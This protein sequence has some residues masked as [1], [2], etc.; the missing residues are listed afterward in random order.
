[1]AD[2]DEFERL[3]LALQAGDVMPPPAAAPAED[4]TSG[5]LEAWL[6]VLAERGGSDLLL[7]AG[8]PPAIR[9]EG[10]VHRLDSG[11]LDSVEIEEAVVSWLPL[12]ARRQ[13]RELGITDASFRIAA[14]ARFRINVHRERGRAA[15]AV[16]AVAVP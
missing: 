3:I 6:R 15:A 5:R 16:A 2:H 12:H 9:I 10:R 14:L 8:A 13:Y 1:M 7:V 4:G 11:P